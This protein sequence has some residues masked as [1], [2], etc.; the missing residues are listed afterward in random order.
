MPF[1]DSS[2]PL[3]SFDAGSATLDDFELKTPFTTL[4]VGTSLIKAADWNKMF[5]AAS[6]IRTTI[7]TEAGGGIGTFGSGDIIAT[8]SNVTLSYHT[9]TLAGSAGVETITS[10]IQTVPAEFGDNP[11][12]DLGFGMAH[13]LNR[14]PSGNVQGVW[15]TGENAGFGR[16]NELMAQTQPLVAITPEAANGTGRTYK[17]RLRNMNFGNAGETISDT[18]KRLGNL[19]VTLPNIGIGVC[20]VPNSSWASW[21][22][23]LGWNNNISTFLSTTSINTTSGWHLIMASTLGNMPTAGYALTTLPTSTDCSLE[24]TYAD[25][26]AI[27]MTNSDIADSVGFGLRMSADGKNFYGLLIGDRPIYATGTY[28]HT[29]AKLVKV[30]N[31]NYST[32]IP[33]TTSAVDGSTIVSYA[34]VY[35]T[36]GRRYRLTLS[37]STLA[38]YEQSTAGGAWTLMSSQT[39]SGGPTSG[40]VGVF[41]IG[42][43]S[44]TAYVSNGTLTAPQGPGRT[45][46]FDN[47]SVSNTITTSALNYKVNI[48]YSKIGTTQWLE[49]DNPSGTMTR[50]Y[51]FDSTDVATPAWNN[52]FEPTVAISSG[53]TVTDTRT[54]GGST[55][56]YAAVII[57]LGQ[58]G[59]AIDL[60]QY[61][62]LSLMM[63]EGGTCT[64]S[65]L[66]TDFRIGISSSENANSESDFYMLPYQGGTVWLG[67]QIF[68]ADLT[69]LTASKRKNIRSIYLQAAVNATGPC[70]FNFGNISFI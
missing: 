54:P 1:R 33:T 66:G 51:R 50:I 41:T 63:V 4:G 47:L 69:K 12:L 28:G 15:Y 3:S 53:I 31:L 24:F 16:I 5:D 26:R 39:V 36:L 11:F 40:K 60:S 29:S 14:T 13:T 18:F 42:R 34:E 62:N 38:I 10:S 22:P 25:Y 59:G 55:K 17:I 19:S 58:Y 49:D 32:T 8:P 37:G 48:L 43:P 65:T 30:T 7:S 67:N 57:R 6:R 45:H 20:L 70:T 56:K 52:T 61:N 64:A 21:T 44:S 2:G 9:V 46:W 23:V 68:D 27:Q 35:L